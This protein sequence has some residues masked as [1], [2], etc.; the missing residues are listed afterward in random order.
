MGYSKSTTNYNFP[1]F[2]ST[3]KPSFLDDW[4][5]AMT[6]IDSSIHSETASAI[7]SATEAS[8]KA[9]EAISS[10]NRAISA[11]NELREDISDLGGTIKKYDFTLTGVNVNNLTVTNE[12]MLMNPRLTAYFIYIPSLAKE[13]L[14]AVNTDL[15]VSDNGVTLKT[16]A[17][18][19]VTINLLLPNKVPTLDTNKIPCIVNLGDKSI[20][21]GTVSY[22]SA[23]GAFSI[24]FRTFEVLSI[25]S[26]QINSAS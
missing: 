21:P 13:I 11:T 12:L 15:Y 17:N 16:M 7:S 18:K 5:L 25:G 20:V 9:N 2:A 22:Y 8:E 3:D 24:I 1:M 23:Q 26:I 19:L 6:V 14:L 4:N 10:A